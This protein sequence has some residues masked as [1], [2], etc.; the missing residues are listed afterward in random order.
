MDQSDHRALIIIGMI[1]TK[2]VPCR[3]CRPA[4]TRLCF[5][6]RTIRDS[7]DHQRV[8]R[9]CNYLKPPAVAGAPSNRLECAMGDR[10]RMDRADI[11]LSCALRL[12]RRDG[13]SLPDP[14]AAQTAGTRRILWDG[15]SEFCHDFAA[16]CRS[17]NGNA[18]RTHCI[19]STRFAQQRLSKPG[20]GVC[21]RQ[22][23]KQV[24][25]QK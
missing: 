15:T 6:C 13:R 2:P 8:W 10:A 4:P 24:Y 20:S 23:R 3:I 17:R 16:A 1:W 22:G 19:I 25:V 11:R 5:A 18:Q 21:D 14:D 12:A 9:P 7:R